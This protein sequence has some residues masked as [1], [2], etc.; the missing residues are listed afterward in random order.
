MLT[1]KQIHEIRSHLEKAQNPLFFFD[2]DPDGLCSFLLLQRALGRGKGIPVKTFPE[3]SGEYFKRINELNADYIFIL[4]K[5]VVSKDFFKECEQINI[6]VVWID[7]HDIKS[8]DIPQF[9]NY[10]NPLFNKDRSNEPVTYLC[11]KTAGKKEDSWIA[12]VGCVCDNFIPDFFKEFS[13]D[14]PDLIGDSKTAPEIYYN[15]Q[16][17]KIAQMMNFGLK[18][19]I[20]NVMKMLKFLM[21]IKTPYELLEETKENKSIYKRFEEVDRKYKKLLDKAMSLDA[22]KKTLFF[23]YGG[24][25]S[26][27]AEIANAL[28]YKFPKKIICVARN[29]GAYTSI[30][31]RGKG[32]RKIVLKIIETLEGA[33]GGG[34]EEAVGGRI[35]TEDSEKFRQ[36]LEEAE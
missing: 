26:I 6:P 5:P 1:E 3:L 35:R 8:E 14:Y 17:G 21:K 29:T 22:K 33:T 2:N 31:L 13:G 27:S 16:L 32:V 24:D 20:T 23:E 28:Q 34:H 30:S 18:D 25:L 10:Y 15:S 12:L 11:H 36:K 7:H 4:D 19:K 9:V